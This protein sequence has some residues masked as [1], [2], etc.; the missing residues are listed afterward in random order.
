M[1]PELPNMETEYAPV[2]GIVILHERAAYNWRMAMRCHALMWKRQRGTRAGG[3]ERQAALICRTKATAA[4]LD[5]L[6]A[7]GRGE[8]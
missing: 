3:L 2:R 7:R 5:A 4:R 6:A 8:E 1:T